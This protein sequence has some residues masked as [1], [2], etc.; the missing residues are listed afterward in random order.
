MGDSLLIHAF[1]YS[2][3]IGLCSVTSNMT[4]YAYSYHSIKL[5]AP[6][7][8]VLSDKIVSPPKRCLKIGARS[9]HMPENF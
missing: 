1:A 2:S 5:I 9:T 4:G 8:D 3:F 6:Q 7:K